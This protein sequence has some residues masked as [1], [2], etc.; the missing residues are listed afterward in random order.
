VVWRERAYLEDEPLVVFQ[1]ICCFLVFNFNLS[2]FR[3]TY[4]RK[5][6]HMYV[7]VATHLEVYQGFLQTPPQNLLQGVQEYWQLE[8]IG[9]PR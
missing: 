3:Y 5:Y 7:N 2:F 8:G 6:S 4:C 1:T 9:S